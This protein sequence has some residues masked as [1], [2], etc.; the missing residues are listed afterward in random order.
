METG[1]GR[2]LIFYFSKSLA[3]RTRCPSL[4]DSWRLC[5][6]AIAY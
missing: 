1:G 2:I 4:Y 3:C 6:F 5:I